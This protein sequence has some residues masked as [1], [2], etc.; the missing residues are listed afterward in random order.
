MDGNFVP[1]CLENGDFAE[2]QCLGSLCWCVDVLG[3][4]KPNTMRVGKPPCYKSGKFTGVIL[5]TN[6]T[7]EK[8]LRDKLVI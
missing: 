4:M 8:S 3:A 1:D 7:T 5:Y 6:I 2:M